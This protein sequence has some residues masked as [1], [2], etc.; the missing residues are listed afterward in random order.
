MEKNYEKEFTIKM[1]FTAIK[2]HIRTLLYFLICFSAIGYFYGYKFSKINYKSTGAVATT[3][4]LSTL[5]Y[6]AVVDTTKYQVPELV[7]ADLTEQGIKHTNGTAITLSEIKNG[8]GWPE[9][10]NNIKSL[11]INFSF[12]NYDKAIVKP[13]LVSI[14]NQSVKYNNEKNV[15]P[16]SNPLSV[17]IAATE[18][19]ATSNPLT[20]LVLFVGAGLVIGGLIIIVKEWN[21]YTIDAPSDLVGLEESVVTI[22]YA[23]GKKNA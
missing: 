18:P 9:V 20:K 1:I 12:T 10:P 11:T 16:A 22:E 3:H 4:T 5:Q 19:T 23:G 17:V 15:V 8:L 14:L 6:G 21:N 2:R 13:V 7:E